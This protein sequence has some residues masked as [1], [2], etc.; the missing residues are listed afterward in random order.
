[1]SDFLS[2]LVANPGAAAKSA[3]TTLVAVAAV[4]AFAGQYVDVPADV[5]AYLAAATA[6]LR[7]LAVALNPKDTSYGLGA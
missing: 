2:K 1:M 3:L 4:L 7:T 5:V 6:V